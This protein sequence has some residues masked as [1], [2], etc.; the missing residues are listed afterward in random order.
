M[1]LNLADLGLD[2]DG[3]P[4]PDTYGA[5][6]LSPDGKRW[7]GPSALGVVVLDLATGKARTTRIRGGVAAI[8]WAPDSRSLLVDSPQTHRTYFLPRQGTTRDAQRLPFRLLGSAFRGQGIV[9]VTAASDG[10]AKLRRWREL[11]PGGDPEI[12]TAAREIVEGRTFGSAYF[13]R[14]GEGPFVATLGETGQR[15]GRVS[16]DGQRVEAVLR[17]GKGTFFVRYLGFGQR[18]YFL[19]LTPEALI[20]WQPERGD[21]RLVFS[22]G[23]GPWSTNAYDAWDLSVALDHIG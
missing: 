3:W 21:L 19:A 22:P 12:S 7:A 23:T 18:G 1:R 9:H 15:L 10:T 17:P 5:G 2:P 11:P 20:A 4:G 13:P 14:E 16:A 8:S 6:H